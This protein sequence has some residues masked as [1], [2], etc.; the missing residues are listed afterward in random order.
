MH[1]LLYLGHHI[2]NKLQLRLFY[3]LCFLLKKLNS[4]QLEALLALDYLNEWHV[5][6]LTFRLMLLILVCFQ[7]YSNI[8]KHSFY[9]IKLKNKFIVNF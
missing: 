7:Q 3:E 1:Y 6:V 9:E 5:M 4:I 2:D 8:L